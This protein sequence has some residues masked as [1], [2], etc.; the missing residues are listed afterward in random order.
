MLLFRVLLPG[1]RL[2]SQATSGDR[3]SDKDLLFCVG[4]RIRGTSHLRV[5][6]PQQVAGI[7]KLF[8]GVDQMPQH[9]GHRCV[10]IVLNVDL[11]V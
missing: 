3:A 7:H 4:S 10:T 5:L 11:D 8:L 2:G 6:L 9:L 1:M